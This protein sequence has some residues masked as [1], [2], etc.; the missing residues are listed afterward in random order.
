MVEW[1]PVKAEEVCSLSSLARLGATG[2]SRILLRVAVHH[3]PVY[4]G[5]DG[6]RECQRVGN[7]GEWKVH[8][9]GAYDRIG[10]AAQYLWAIEK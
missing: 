4:T 9:R 10:S 2:C 3:R 7:G 6:D 1:S 5:W 8:Y